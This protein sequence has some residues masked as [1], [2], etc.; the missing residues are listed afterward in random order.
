MFLCAAL[1]QYSIRTGTLLF[2]ITESLEAKSMSYEFNNNISK[3]RQLADYIRTDIANG[4]YKEGD[5]LPSINK[6]SSQYKIAR[7]TVFKAFQ[8]LKEKGIIESTP[9]KGYFVSNTTNNILVM[10]DVFT[11]FKNDLYNE[12]MSNL[13]AHYK[14]DLFFHNFS[15]RA[16]NN[17]ILDNQGRYNLYVITNIIN[18]VYSET[19]DRLD[20]SKVLLIDLGKFKKDKFS[21]ICQGFDSTLYE[22]LTSG[23]D[24]LRKYNKIVFLFPPSAEHPKSSLPYFEKFCT[25]YQFDYQIRREEELEEKDIVPGTA[26]L[27]AKHSDMIKVVKLC[28]TKNLKLGKDVGL[29]TFNDTPM[30]EVIEDGIS[31]ISTNFR[32]MGRLAAEYIKTREKIQTYIP[33]KL[34][35]RGSL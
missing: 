14:L 13:P 23:L 22:C 19:L 5:L 20:N 4:K 27:A 34:I 6:I 11:P 9:T 31:V 26:Y 30:L 3:V 32:E 2:L 8:E 7:D 18:D 17:I 15:E 1:G 12:L 16:F 35:L 24:V 33:T 28:K 29:V 25:D 10:F 21:Y